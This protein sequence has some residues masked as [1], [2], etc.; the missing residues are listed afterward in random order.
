MTLSDSRRTL[1]ERVFAWLGLTG[2]E[3]DAVYEAAY[4]AVVRRQAAEG[5]T[6][7]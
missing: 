7:N 2:D 3:W 4:D 6:V 1:D 5:G